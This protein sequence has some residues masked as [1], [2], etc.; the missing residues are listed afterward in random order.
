MIF[1]WTELPDH[2]I[3]KRKQHD[4]QTVASYQ[5]IIIPNFLV[6]KSPPSKKQQ[7]LEDVWVNTEK[8]KK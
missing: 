2:K 7:Q 3:A 5:M 8:A 6:E 4:D 1:V